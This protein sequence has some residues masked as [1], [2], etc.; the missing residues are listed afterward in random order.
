MQLPARFECENSC[1]CACAVTRPRC[2]RA[3]HRALCLQQV[4]APLNVIYHACNLKNHSCSALALR[5]DGCV[6]AVPVPDK[7]LDDAASPFLCIDVPL[8]LDI[9]DHEQTPGEQDPSDIDMK[10]PLFSLLAVEG[11]TGRMCAVPGTSI[12][13]IAGKDVGGSGW[14][15]HLV[16]ADALL[17][18][19]S[20]LLSP[21]PSGT[22]SSKIVSL[23]AHTVDDGTVHV[24]AALLRSDSTLVWAEASLS[25]K[26]IPHTGQ[27]ATASSVV[28]QLGNSVA[29]T[30]RMGDGSTR[31]LL[32]DD[33]RARV[34]Q[35][36][37]NTEIHAALLEGNLLLA[38]RAK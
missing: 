15:V 29:E 6:M 3:D 24:A 35:V 32:E 30:Q 4:L 14:T 17:P 8:Q 31:L 22:S 9:I 12:V 16:D 5:R 19:S 18:L 27:A 37:S 2:V 21:L 25:S 26:G 38:W 28:F 7:V 20:A 10:L 11:G 23:S 13:A 1:G 36:V 33:G 34:K